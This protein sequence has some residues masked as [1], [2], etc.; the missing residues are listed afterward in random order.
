MTDQ[1]PPIVPII[2]SGGSGTRL[3]PLSRRL[4]PKQFAALV[5]DLTMFQ[6]TAARLAGMRGAR[7]A[8]VVCNEAHG[9]LAAGQLD[10]LGAPPEVVIMEPLGRNTAPAVAVAALRAMAGGDDPLLLVLPADHMIR[11]VLAFQ[12]AVAVGAPLASAGKLVTFGIVPDRPHTGYGYI[13]RGE[14]IEAGVSYLVQRF[15]EKPDAAT[16][17]NYVASGEYSWNS[18]M[19]LFRASRFLEELES[20][21]PEMLAGSRAALSAG[22][23]TGA[24]ILLDE[25]AFAATPADSIDYAVMEHTGDAAVVPL[26]AGWSDVGAWPALWEIADGDDDGNVVRGDVML[27]G[28][29]GSFVR[30]EGRLVAVVGVEDVVVVETPDAV[31]VTSRDRAEGVKAI[32]ERLRNDGRIESERHRD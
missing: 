27:D 31:L 32:V 17:A 30:A 5:G 8:F 1:A 2:L 20:H 12:A 25:E 28:V 29:T 15:V 6:E 23:E 3:W 26:E 11:D 24:G 14:A 9:A 19:F 18:G 4:H 13:Q 22:A 16:A 7:P 10:E 21:A